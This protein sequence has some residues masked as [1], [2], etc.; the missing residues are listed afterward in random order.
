MLNAKRIYAVL[1]RR[2]K[3]V[4]IGISNDPDARLKGLQTGSAH[5][6]EMIGHVAGSFAAEASCHA[7]L[8]DHSL[9]GE[10]FKWNASVQEFVDRLLGFGVAAAVSHQERLNFQKKLSRKERYQPPSNTT[11]ES[12]VELIAMLKKCGLSKRAAV[13]VAAGGYNALMY[14]GETPPAGAN[15][16]RVID[17]SGVSVY[18]ARSRQ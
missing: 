12:K 4:K 3:S 16:L 13:L 2:T 9:N 15:G 5:D 8:A 7:A 14:H 10:W 1:D 18:P 11:V 17:I 6:L